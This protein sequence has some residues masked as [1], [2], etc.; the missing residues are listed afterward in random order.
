MHPASSIVCSS[1][2]VVI[3]VGSATQEEAEEDA[4][5]A[6]QEETQEDV[7]QSGSP[8]GKQVQRPVAVGTNVSAVLVV[9][10][11]INRVDPHIT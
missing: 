3:W 9:V 6:K 1:L 10:G 4:A 11:L 8:E 5:A 7:D 2:D